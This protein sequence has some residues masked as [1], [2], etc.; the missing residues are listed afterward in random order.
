MD[1]IDEYKRLEEDQQ[2]GKG[3]AKVVPQDWRYFR[4]DRY[5][6]SRPR[7]DF[8]GHTGSTIAQVVNTVFREPPHDAALVVTLRIGGYDVKRVLVD[9]GS[10]AEIMYPNLYKELK[11]K[12]EDLAYYDSPFA[13]FDGKTLI[14]KNQIRLP[15]QA[16]LE[17][18]EVDFIVVDAYSPYTAIMARPWL[19]SMRTISST[20][21]LKVKYPLEDQVK[22][23]VGSQSMTKQCLVATIRHQTGGESSASTEKDL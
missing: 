17:V 20:L 6:N 2:Q 4:S 12:L 19:H 8:V 1:R 23:L 7:R 13:G 18:V 10:G 9:Q 11:L 14:S 22:E 16:G 21:H 15:V 5:N 3:K